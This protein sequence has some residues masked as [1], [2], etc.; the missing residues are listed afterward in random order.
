VVAAA[1][2]D[3]LAAESLVW[4]LGGLAVW[5]PYR[6]QRWPWPSMAT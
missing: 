3:D 1:I 4:R 5:L 6:A 2:L